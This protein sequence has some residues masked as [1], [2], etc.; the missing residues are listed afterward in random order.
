MSSKTMLLLFAAVLAVAMAGVFASDDDT[1]DALTVLGDQDPNGTFSERASSTHTIPSM[2]GP[3]AF[4]PAMKDQRS[5]APDRAFQAMPESA[6]PP[7]PPM[8][9]QGHG[10][11]MMDGPQMPGFGAHAPK[12]VEIPKKDVPPKTEEIIEEYEK[13]FKEK[14]DQKEDG[15]P[16]IVI[17]HNV[18]SGEEAVIVSAM[19]EVLDRQVFEADFLVQVIDVLESKGE[20]K[21]ADT[22]RAV[23]DSRFVE[24]SAVV[25]MQQ[26]GNGK[27]KDGSD[28]AEDDM[29]D[30]VSVEDAEDEEEESPMVF[31][32][33]SD[34]GVGVLADSMS[35]GMNFCVCYDDRGRSAAI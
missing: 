29:S 35:A 20:V 26:S 23:L 17:D 13:A 3:G 19:Q 10:P 11:Q 16:V 18:Y 31:D 27:S 14:K 22:V 32:S 5:Y 25:G 9:G 6:V 15:N 30:P 33:P 28:D 8:A 2:T 7:Q 4:Q 24:V 34:N 12:A 1:C 21:A